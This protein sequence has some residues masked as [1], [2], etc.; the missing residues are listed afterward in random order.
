[1]EW[2]TT[3]A[4]SVRGTPL[5]GPRDSEERLQ[6]QAL[7]PTVARIARRFHAGEHARGLAAMAAAIMLAWLLWSLRRPIPAVDDVDLR[8][9]SAF[10]I[11]MPLL[12]PLAWVQHLVVVI[13]A[14]MLILTRTTALSSRNG[15]ALALFGFLTLALN[16]EFLGRTLYIDL[17]TYGL[18]TAALL[19]LLAT[20]AATNGRTTTPARGRRCSDADAQRAELA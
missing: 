14:L 2:T 15:V 20:L 4:A 7:A 1:M 5:P 8:D 12:A 17:L 13:P 10:L 11:A 16:R 6:N 19:L 9:L 18:H 3:V